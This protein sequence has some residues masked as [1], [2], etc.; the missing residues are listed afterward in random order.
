[1]R[2][3]NSASIV[4]AGYNPVVYSSRISSAARELADRFLG[5]L[6]DSPVVLDSDMNLYTAITAVGPTYFLPI[7]DAVISA[8]I[9]G[10]LSQIAAVETARG[11]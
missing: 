4:G 7:F 5:L 6:G 3:P 10:G 2:A 9:A 1:V 8:G 11:R